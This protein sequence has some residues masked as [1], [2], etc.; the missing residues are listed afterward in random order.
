MSLRLLNACELGKPIIH[1]AID[2]I[3]SF[4]WVLI[5]GIVYASKDIAGAKDANEG[6]QLMLNAWS[7]VTESVAGAKFSAT[8]VGWE[9]D[10]VFGDLIQ[11]WLD[12]TRRAHK[13]TRKLIKKMSK[14]GLKSLE[15]NR[16]CSE[17]DS[18][19]KHVYKVVLESGFKHLEGV[20]EYPDWDEVVAANTGR[21]AKRQRED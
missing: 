10:T 7:G 13:E 16:A 2:D 8:D 9:D 11:E 15:W 18:Y 19:C 6:I 14:M 20:R 1:T 3:E 21:P 4:L 12:T 17:L 5:W